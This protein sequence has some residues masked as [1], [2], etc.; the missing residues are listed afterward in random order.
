MTFFRNVRFFNFLSVIVL[1][2]ALFVSGALVTRSL[3]VG[4]DGY[5]SLETFANILAIVRQNYVDEVKTQELVDGAIKGMLGSLDPHSAYL[6]EELYKDLQ[7]E[8]Q[9]RFG[10]LGIEVTVRDGILTVVSP[11][12]DTP[13]ARVGIQPGD[14]IFKIEDELTKDMGL[15]GAVKRLRGPT[16]SSVNISVR[17]KGSNKLLNFKIVRDVIKIRSVRS[18]ELKPGFVYVRL[19]QFQ[20]NSAADL[21]AALDKGGPQDGKVKGLILDLRNNPGGL[22]NQ[23]VKVSDLFLDSGLI[24]Y[25]DGRL[26]HQKQK[27]SANKKG[28]WTEFPMV[29]LVNS[30]SASASEIVAGALQDHK[31]AIVLGTQTFGKGSVQTILPLNDRSALRLTT[32]KYFTP[33]G[34]SIQAKGIEPDIIMEQSAPAAERTTDL[35]DQ[36]REE[37]LPGHLENPGSD[38]PQNA[39]SSVDEDVTQRILQDP[40]VKRALELLKGW[41][42]FK[43]L[44]E[45]EQK[46]AA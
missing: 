28:T 2:G 4:P 27:F 16:G 14:Q 6:T 23:A 15:I 39:E 11:I 7:T 1:A 21:R 42:V 18:Y 10:G 19:A 32:A 44:G 25:T 34:R 24:V 22:L 37:N 13:A 12:E 31:R 3:A 8:T 33:N 35:R 29:V 5:E 20:E 40:Q 41:E 30:G 9:G 17:R 26:A 36:L 45:T 46:K 38:T 43:Q